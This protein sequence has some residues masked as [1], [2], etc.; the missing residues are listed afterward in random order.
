MT[1][2]NSDEF[3]QDEILSGFHYLEELA[4]DREVM[5]NPDGYPDDDWQEG[6]IDWFSSFDDDPFDEAEAWL[7]AH[8]NGVTE[9]TDPSV[10]L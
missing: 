2:F 3:Q 10:T 8:P 1:V 5:S 9:V 4:A 7:S 6:Y